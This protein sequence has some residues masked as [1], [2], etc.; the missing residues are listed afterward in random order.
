M[1]DM[2]T[3]FWE[4]GESREYVGNAYGESP[5][6]R[7]TYGVNLETQTRNKN[8]TQMTDFGSDMM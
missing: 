8:T 4:L 7:D 3:K 5:G 1:V 2:G 6:G